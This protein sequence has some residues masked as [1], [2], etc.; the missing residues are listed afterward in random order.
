M[1]E[2]SR[3]GIRALKRAVHLAAASL[4]IAGV[5]AVG[6]CLSRPIEPVD[7]RTTSVVLERLTQSG[8]NKIDL[9][10]VV[11][12][13]ASM[14]DKQYILSLA[15]PDLIVG[16]VNPKCIDD[17]SGQPTATQPAGPTELCPAGSTRDFPPVED[18][19]IGLLSSSLGSFGADG[20]KD[21]PPT[22]CTGTP[23]NTTSNN[24]HGHLITRADPCT[25]VPV[26]TYQSKGFLAWDPGKKLNPVGET[27]IAGLTGSLTQI[28]VGDGQLGCGFEA[29]NEAWYRFLIDPSPYQSIALVNN[30]VQLNGIDQALLDQR[31]AFLRPD[32]LLAIINVTDET[33]TSIKQYSSYP[34]FAAPELHLPHARQECTAPGK[35]PKDPCCASCGQAAPAGCP[36]DA[37]CASNGSYSATD[38]NTSLRAFGLIG[39]KARYGIEFFYQPSRYV[40]ALTSPTVADV[41]GKQVTNPIY[42]NLDTANYKG[43]VRDPGLVFYAAIVGVPWQ[44]IARQ[45]NG[46]PD[47]IGGV[48]AVDPTQIGGFKNA[49]ELSLTDGKGNTYWDDIAGDPENYVA[50]KSPFMQESTTPRS[51]TDPITGAAISPPS[52]PNQGGTKIGGVVLNDHERSIKNPPDDIEYACVFDLPAGHQVDCSKAGTSCDCNNGATDNPLCD[53]NPADSNKL[54]LQTRAKAYPGIKH[55]AIARGMGGQGIAASICPKQLTDDKADDY[56]YRPAVKAIIDRL[57]LALHGQCLPRQLAPDAN[58]QVQCLILEASTTPNCNCDPAAARSP[59]STEHLPAEDAA[60]ADPLNKTA[61]WNCF[62]EINQLSGA[63]LTDCQTAPVPGGNT[64]GWCYVDAAVNAQQAAIV[65]KCPPSEQHEIRFAGKGQPNPGTTLFITCA[66]Q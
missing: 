8:V 45:K 60:K 30:Q 15:I 61:N 59:V 23:P 6:G 24:D 18:I 7:P 28:V 66:G 55:L 1:K 43:A 5:G 16:L 14:A 22:A 49:K 29:Q 53:P 12:N 36:A 54:T 21:V 10:L 9:V 64:N 4:A 51:G 62:C 44:L 31:K 40:Q 35:G 52:T 2:Q 19:H 56:G 50:A 3:L 63:P 26:P 34:L 32:S 42:S 41:N 33:D 46:V 65:A 58:D 47:L 13:S 37:M 25:S 57:K 27:T 38:E 17:K 48:S 11:D 20:C 39:H